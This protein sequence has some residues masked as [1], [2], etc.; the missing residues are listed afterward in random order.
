MSRDFKEYKAERYTPDN[1]KIPEALTEKAYV[2]KIMVNPS[3]EYIKATQRTYFSIPKCQAVYQRR[4]ID[5]ETT[6][7]FLKGSPGST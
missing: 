4:K 2:R 5:V 6:F 1:Q 7:G 3:W